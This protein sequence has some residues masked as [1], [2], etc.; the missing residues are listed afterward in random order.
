M[1]LQPHPLFSAPP[2]R[3]DRLGLR[4]RGRIEPGKRAD[5]VLLDP[6]AYVDTATY[7]EPLRSPEGVKG[8]WVDGVRAL[9]DGRPT[10]ARPGGVVR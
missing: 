6:G 7:A 10:G 9:E 4:D 1:R 3:A 5:L 8:V 2:R